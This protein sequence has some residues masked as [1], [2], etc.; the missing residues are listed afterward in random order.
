MP[1][2]S[3]YFRRLGNEAQERAER[4]TNPQIKLAFSDV[5]TGWFTLAEQTAW[6]DRRDE[7]EQQDTRKNREDRL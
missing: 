3:E 2:K 6:L 1:S 7:A 5:A 4:A